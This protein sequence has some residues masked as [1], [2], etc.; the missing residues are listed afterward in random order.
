MRKSLSAPPFSLLILVSGCPDVSDILASATADKG[1]SSSE[2]GSTLP[3]PTTAAT[4]TENME[5]S[6][7]SSTSTTWATSTTATTSTSDETSTTDQTLPDLPPENI[8]GDGIPGGVNEECDDGHERNTA[9]MEYVPMPPNLSRD[10]LCTANCKIV[11]WCGD[12]DIFSE[13]NEECDDGDLDDTDEC[14][15][16]CS[17][18]R[19]VFV[20]AGQYSGL[21]IGGR[22]SGLEGADEI[23]KKEAEF[24]LAELSVGGYGWRAWLASDSLG[25][26]DRIKEEQWKGYYMTICDPEAEPLP[27]AKWWD[28]LSEPLLH[29]IN[30]DQ[31]GVLHDLMNTTLSTRVTWSNV[32][33]GGSP[34][35]AENNCSGWTSTTGLGE[36]GNLT[37]IDSSWTEVQN[38]QESC[39]ELR[40]LYCIQ[41]K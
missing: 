25:P 11:K 18:P 40:R 36:T 37:S 15:N 29:P 24:G 30:C 22:P 7:S 27:V 12:G 4:S 17:K 31:Y 35:D 13:E 1:S 21:L 39:A 8:C 2:E 10:A 38:G 26:V 6:I 19:Y 14:S 41:V 5:T 28:G 32:A 33:I 23:C 9:E 20:T 34:K 16:E 3:T